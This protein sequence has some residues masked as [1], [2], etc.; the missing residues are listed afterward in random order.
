MSTEQELVE[1]ARQGDCRAFA[2]LVRRHEGRLYRLALGI[3]H[4]AE[5]AEDAV[6]VT[7]VSSL[8]H[9]ADFRGDWVAFGGWLNRIAANTALQMLAR[10]RD[11]SL[12]GLGG[13]VDESFAQRRRPQ[14]P[15]TLD[16]HEI[17]ERREL[18]RLLDEAVAD[19]PDA[20]RLVFVLRELAG[21]STRETAE[22]LGAPE[23]TVKVRLLRA[24]LALRD[25]LG[26]VF[27][28]FETCVR[29]SSS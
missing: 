11:L 25:R 19:L 28:Q 23:G 17:A 7:L 21:L 12:E 24:R 8:E 5:D 20:L 3:L 13:S 6:Q 15:R 10:R 22:R 29:E 9:V 27:R 1:R 16:P 18:Q 26:P 4:H 14:I 2:S